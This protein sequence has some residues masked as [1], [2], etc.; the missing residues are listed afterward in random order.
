M[1]RLKQLSTGHW[2]IRGDGPCNWA[3]VPN[4]PTTA[5]ELRKHAFPGA[6][7]Q[8][9][10]ETTDLS[11]FLAEHANARTPIGKVLRFFEKCAP[12]RVA[13]GVLVSDL[14]ISTEE[15]RDAVKDLHSHGLVDLFDMGLIMI[16][17]SRETVVTIIRP[18]ISQTSDRSPSKA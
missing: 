10:Q 16:G 5:D 13:L 14:K 11:N 12:C 9:L 15:A 3:Q 2:H 7:T 4:W 1:I 18:A 6:S 17:V 8:F